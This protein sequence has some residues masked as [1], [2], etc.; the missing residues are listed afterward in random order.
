MIRRVLSRLKVWDSSTKTDKALNNN[1][2]SGVAALNRRILQLG[3]TVDSAR[4]ESVDEVL[5]SIA[6]GV[7]YGALQCSLLE[8]GQNVSNADLAK[9]VDM[10]VYALS[11]IGCSLIG[12]PGQSVQFEPSLHSSLQP[13]LISGEDIRISV[14][15]LTSPS[16]TVIRK[17]VVSRLS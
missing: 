3:A 14:P 11:S 16:G 9:A 1:I 15:G 17:A 7:C 8:S 4:A 13:S 10:V 2:E 6:Q 12:S 5:Q